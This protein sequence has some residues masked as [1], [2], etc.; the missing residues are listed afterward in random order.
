MSAG[1]TFL[2]WT[3][4]LEIE[5]HQRP[6]PHQTLVEPASPK[7]PRLSRFRPLALFERLPSAHV[8]GVVMQA[9]QDLHTKDSCTAAN[10]AW[11]ASFKIG[12]VIAFV[13]HSWEP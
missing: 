1:R 10:N 4:V 7:S 11:T 3:L 9:Y 6:R 8:D 13:T 5:A 2:C 12:L